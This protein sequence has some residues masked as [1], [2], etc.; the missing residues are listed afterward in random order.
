MT[1]DNDSLPR[2]FNLLW[3][4]VVGLVGA[5]LLVGEAIGDRADPLIVGA[6]L[7]AMGLIPAAGIDTIRGKLSKEESDA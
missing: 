1:H 5:G 4:A 3:K 2:W 7:L 6:G